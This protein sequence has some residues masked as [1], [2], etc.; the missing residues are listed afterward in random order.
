MWWGAETVKGCVCV[1][2]LHTFS[3]ARVKVNTH[4]P[5]SGH[6]YKH[7]Q[8]PACRNHTTR[9]CVYTIHCPDTHTVQLW[10][11]CTLQVFSSELPLNL[12]WPL[13][14]SSNAADGKPRPPY[15]WAS[16]PWTHR[17]SHYLPLCLLCLL[18]WALQGPPQKVLETPATDLNMQF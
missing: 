9:R 15:G 11:M 1:S 5:L 7:V 14:Q 18:S 16:C 4:R 6:D 10:A 13:Q 8:N 2:V 12:Q 17:C 3:S